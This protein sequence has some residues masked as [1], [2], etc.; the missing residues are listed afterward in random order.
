[1]CVYTESL[2][3]TGSSHPDRVQL[4]SSAIYSTI[5]SSTSSSYYERERKRRKGSKRQQ[6]F[7]KSITT[8]TPPHRVLRVGSSE[9]RLGGSVPGR[10][11]LPLP[12]PLSLALY[13]LPMCTVHAHT[14]TYI[15]KDKHFSSYVYATREHT[16]KRRQ[17]LLPVRTYV[18]YVAA[19]SLSIFFSMHLSPSLK[20]KKKEPFLFSSAHLKIH[21]DI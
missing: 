19:S 15:P 14:H 3:A 10:S 13:T 12:L 5:L 1:V 18:S 6:R 21:T 2:L 9:H 8:R 4:C 11:I 7:D 17:E 16:R 20:K